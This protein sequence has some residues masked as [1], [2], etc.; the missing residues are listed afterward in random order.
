MTQTDAEKAYLQ[1][2]DRIVRVKMAP[3]SVIREQEL[4][5]ELGLGRTP[6][7]E[8]LKQL[9]NENLV[10]VVPRR[11]MFVADISITDL[12][13]I[14]EVRLEIEPLRLAAERISPEQLAELRQL[15]AEA[16]TI[17]T[18]DVQ[19]TLALDGRFHRLMAKACG[20]RFLRSQIEMLYH[21]SLRIWHLSLDRLC[22]RDVDLE[23]HTEILTAIQ[24]GDGNLARQRMR[25]HS[26]HFQ[27]TVKVYL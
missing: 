21:L 7:R 20:N 26:Q 18:E 6:I 1:I 23:A 8:A 12:H 9:H 4:M 17:D 24:Q 16:Q 22:P 10:V 3:G 25:R 13:Q 5:A 14:Y 15:A 19:A 27:D 2:R 11:G